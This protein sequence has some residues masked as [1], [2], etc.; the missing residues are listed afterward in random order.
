MKKLNLF[1]LDDD[2][3]RWME[4]YLSGRSQSVLI[5]GCMSPPLS[6]YCGVPQGSILGPL[7][8]ILFTNEIPDLVHSHPVSSTT[9]KSFCEDCGGTVCYVDDATFSVGHKD[10]D[11]LSSKLSEQYD[12]IAEYMAANKLVINGDKTHLVVMGNKKAGD[13]RGQV[14]L[15]AGE[16]LVL[17]SQTEKLL[18]CQ[19]S[20]DLDWKHHLLVSDESMTKQLTSRV[21][22]LCLISDLATFETRLMVANGIFMSKL[23][24]LVQLW[25]GCDEYLLSALQ[26]I[27]NRAARIVSRLSWFTPVR[28]LLKKCKWLSVRQLILYQSVIL[29]HKIASTGSPASLAEKMST[30]HPYNTRQANSGS[31]RYG[32]QFS[33]SDERGHS[34]FCY[35]GTK[36]YNRIPAFI[37]STKFLPSFKYKLRKWIEENIPLT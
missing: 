2:A 10:P 19:I 16:H 23:C 7:M 22:G 17:P 35:R 26:I 28:I 32:E 18:G 31:I 37:R 24:Y 36:D 21:N 11:T 3:A 12:T 15:S 13:V 29:T 5:D 30:S 14:S 8:Y 1:G 25:G 4:S 6:I 27:Q 20:E 9:P 33:S 34:S